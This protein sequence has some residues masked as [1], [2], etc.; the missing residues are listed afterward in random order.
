MYLSNKEKIEFIEETFSITVQI[1]S[2]LENM[3]FRIMVKDDSFS[4]TW[5]IN[6]VSNHL[7]GN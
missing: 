2:D 3:I 7:E 4:I 6:Q 1:G 5:F